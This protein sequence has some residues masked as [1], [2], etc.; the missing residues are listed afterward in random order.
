M[1]DRL[2]RDPFFFGM[3]VVF[4]W[5]VTFS[6]VITFYIFRDPGSVVGA[7][8]SFVVASLLF[9]WRAA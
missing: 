6:L 8:V 9:R 4:L 5:L 1:Q 3:I 2:K 7:V